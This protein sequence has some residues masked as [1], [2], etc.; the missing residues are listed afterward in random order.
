MVDGGWFQFP[1]NGLL[2]QM[3]AK[4]NEMLALQVLG[5][6]QLEAQG[7]QFPETFM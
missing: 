7:F 2:L 4:G 6:G 3:L 5:I 1:C